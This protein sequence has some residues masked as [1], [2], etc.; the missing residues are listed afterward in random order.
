MQAPAAGTRKPTTKESPRRIAVCVGVGLLLIYLA[1]WSP[2]LSFYLNF[3]RV[4]TARANA[5]PLGILTAEPREVETRASSWRPS[6]GGELGVLLPP[7]ELTRVSPQED[8][9]VLSFS[10]GE[11]LV[12]RFE[13]GFL[14][15]LLA[16]RLEDLG[17][18]ADKGLSDTAAM[19]QIVPVTLAD[20]ELRQGS[21]E[22]HRY[23]AHIIAKLLLF[24]GG[25]VKRVDWCQRAEPEG[26]AILVEYDSGRVI[27]LI[28]AEHVW[29]VQVP[30]EVPST[31][32]ESPADWLPPQ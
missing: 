14:S 28:V 21:S 8:G 27:L 25:G 29:K 31:W 18:E 24:E 16:D 20:Y 19:V 5:V 2:N 15:T 30:A 7:G 9:F 12:S 26:G 11:I 6:A 3:Q 32:T 1:T 22:N 13:K 4:V 23:A 10:E 17:A